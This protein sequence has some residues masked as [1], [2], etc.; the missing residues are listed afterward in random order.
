MDDDVDADVDVDVDVSEQSV[1]VYAKGWE[2]CL[3]G[4]TLLGDATRGGGAKGCSWLK[5]SRNRFPWQEQLR[6]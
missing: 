1:G 6:V 3:A 5:L 4:R 2:A